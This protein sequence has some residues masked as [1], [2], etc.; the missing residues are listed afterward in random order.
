MSASS[1][2]ERPEF[3]AD[4]FVALD[5]SEPCDFLRG[6][7]R[8]SVENGER[9]GFPQEAGLIPAQD[10]GRGGSAEGQHVGA[11]ALAG[12]LAG[13]CVPWN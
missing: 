1:R 8:D 11:E 9:G 2:S 5:Q 4:A 3:D 6:G 13:T 7:H 12:R 10:W